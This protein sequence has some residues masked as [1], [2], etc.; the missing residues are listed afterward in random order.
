MAKIRAILR[1]AMAS[2]NYCRSV[3]S[4]SSFSSPSATIWSSSS[5]RRVWACRTSTSVRHGPLSKVFAF[6]EDHLQSMDHV[7]LPVFILGNRFVRRLAVPFGIAASAMTGLRDF[8]CL[9]ARIALDAQIRRSASVCSGA[10]TSAC[11]ASVKFGTA[12]QAI[13]VAVDKGLGIPVQTWPASP[14]FMVRPVSGLQ[15]H[16]RCSTASDRQRTD[17]P[18]AGPLRVAG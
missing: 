18:L 10:L 11:R 7:P 14:E 4:N 3:D 6:R 1:V 2:R 12:T 8:P 9:V 15:A 13:D 5:A 17:R 16:R